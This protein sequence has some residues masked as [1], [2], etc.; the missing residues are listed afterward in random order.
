MQVFARILGGIGL[1]LVTL[2]AVGLVLPGRWEVEESATV[3]AAPDSVSSVLTRVASWREWMPWPESGA[4]FRG[5]RFGPGASFR[6]D[7]PTYG[8]GRFTITEAVPGRSLRYRVAVEDGSIAVE[9]RLRL[10]AADGGTRIRWTE[11]GSVGWNPLLGYVALTMED[12]Q[13]AQLRTVLGELER[14]LEEGSRAEG[15]REG[16]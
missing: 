8:A 7:D 3:R 11:R 14:Y 6:W 10:E 5:P 1:L 13:R 15:S 16:G 12:R 2:I 4:E 9:G